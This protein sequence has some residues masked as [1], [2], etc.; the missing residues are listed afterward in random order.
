MKKVLLMFSLIICFMICGCAKNTEKEVLSKFSKKI[1]NAKS[2][3]LTGTLEMV[4][5]ETSY[6]YDVNVSY[7]K[8]NNF[9]VSLK[10]QSNDH[11]Q[12]ILRNEDGVYVITPSLNKS[13]KFQSEWPYNNSQ[14]YLLQTILD[15]LESDEKYTY[16]NEDDKHIFTSSVN[17]SNNTDLVK[18][19]VTINSNYEVET[20][21]VLDAN[22]NVKIKM[23]FND[24][25]YKA[26]FNADYYS[27]EQNVSSEVTG[28]DEVSTIE[29]VIYPMYIPVNTSLSSQDK[30]NTSTGERVILTFDGESP[31]MFI[32]ENATASSEFTTI[33]VNGELVMLGGTIGVLDD[34]SISWISDGME[35][36]LVSSTLNDEQL[37]EVARS[38]GSIPVIK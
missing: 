32:Q 23:T 33:P 16:V 18:Q 15:D 10:N 29:D 12:I 3:Y 4:N 9:K 25:D 38:I 6:T 8:E 24:I 37:L 2:Y 1:E 28:T 21:E 19:K 26:K 31:F 36:Y 20:V 14:A 13:F 11:E 7:T 17:Y 30:V 5:N 27:L 34:S 35:Y 22:D